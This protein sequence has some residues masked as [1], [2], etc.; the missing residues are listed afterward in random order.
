MVISRKREEF[1]KTLSDYVQL[2]LEYYIKNA[3]Y[4]L[5]A[6]GISIICGLLFSVVFARFLSREIYGQYNYIFSILGI[7]A[8]FSLP[9]MNIAIAQGVARGYDGLLI[10]GTKVKIKWSILG[11]LVV[12]LVGVYYYLKGSIILAKC[13]MISSM[14]FLPYFGL[15]TFSAFLSG[16]KLF[17]KVS[18]Y[19]SASQIFSVLITIIV[20]YFSR[21]LIWILVTYL[22]ST[23]LTNLYFL[24]RTT[25]TN[26]IDDRSSIDPDA[27]AFGKHMTLLNLIMNIRAHYDRIIIGAFLGFSD[28]AIYS[29]AV[30]FSDQ[31]KTLVSV[32]RDLIFPKLSEMDQKIAYHAVKKRLPYLIF[33][34]AVI[35]GIGIL[36]CP[37]IIPLFYSQKYLH[38]ILYTQ[39]LLISVMITAPAMMLKGGVF[40]SQRKIGELFKANTSVSVIEI[41][42]LTL[43]VPNFG[44][45]GAATTKL[46]SRLFDTLYSW[47]LFK[48]G[49]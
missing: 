35:C 20:I 5:F 33:I 12:F 46:L 44:L 43:L 36:L 14:F 30:V 45:L 26:R 48:S 29:I 2:D 32:I 17:N 38:S 49:I 42:L 1:W 25:K 34:F 13:L 11:C 19:R 31:V 47:R 4:L 15:T 27:I 6:N 37:Y 39:I 10:N 22:A 16:K 21:N 3:F 23:S 18:K 7:L 41:I 8:I 40:K 9:G 24:F 28:L